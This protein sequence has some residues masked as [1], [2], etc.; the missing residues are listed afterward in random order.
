[1][2]RLGRLFVA[3]ALTLSAT[4]AAASSFWPEPGH[5]VS[6][7]GIRS[8]ARRLGATLK[9]DRYVIDDMEFPV[10]QVRFSGGFT[11]APWPGGRLV[12]DATGVSANK[13]AA[14]RAACGWWEK[15]SSVRCVARTNETGGYMR[16]H[17]V[18]GDTSSTTVGFPGSGGVSSMRLC[19]SA[20]GH[21]AHEIGHALGLQHEQSRKGR[22]QFVRIH[23]ENIA[24]DYWPQFAEQNTVNYGTYDFLSI[25]HYPGKARSK[26][27]RLT[28]E[29]LPPNQAMQSA[30]G[31]KKKL[32]DLDAAGMAAKY[33]KP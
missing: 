16:I 12:Y 30:L 7:A 8:E 33:G 2:T 23:F 28:I 21:V 20:V 14:F 29:V 32:S 27:G 9:G 26:N 5:R 13:V 15:V 24:K 11:S 18:G 22:D 6:A 25:M 1:M 17:D 3:T 19:C 4:G 31:N 10:R